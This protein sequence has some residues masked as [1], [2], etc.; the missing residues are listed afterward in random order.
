MWPL[1]FAVPRAHQMALKQQQQAML[2]RKKKFEDLIPVIGDAP[3]T[4]FCS[5]KWQERVEGL[6]TVGRM[7]RAKMH[8]KRIMADEK[9]IAEH[10]ANVTKLLYRALGDKVCGLVAAG[11]S[12]H[13]HWLSLAPPPS[14]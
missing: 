2:A 8:A 5:S 11:M 7:L 3:I 1:A 14:P 13:H 10:F 12:Q 6:D 4:A 9:G